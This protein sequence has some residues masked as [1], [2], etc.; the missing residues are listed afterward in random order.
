ME[1]GLTACGVAYRLRA[2]PL[3]IALDP[4]SLKVVQTIECSGEILSIAEWAKE[5]GLTHQR[6]RQRL[7]RYPVHVALSGIKNKGRRG[8][9]YTY[10]LGGKTQTLNEWAKEL[11]LPS[12]TLYERLRIAGEKALDSN[13]KPNRGKYMFR[14]RRQTLMAWAKELGVSAPALYQRLRKVGR[15]PWTQT[16]NQ[17][18]AN[19]RL[20]AGRKR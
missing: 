18:E 1:L 9:M 14:G 3:E 12:Y 20:A 13:Y 4:G 8:A 10:T 2:F 11:G 5:L 17:S 19:T 7:E 15:R 6:I 16:T